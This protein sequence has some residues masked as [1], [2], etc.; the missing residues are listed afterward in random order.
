MSLVGVASTGRKL[1]RV[2]PVLAGLV[3]GAALGPV[4]RR[5][6]HRAVVPTATTR[7]RT[8]RGISRNGSVEFQK[9]RHYEA[10]REG[11]RHV[12]TCTTCHG[13]V[14]ASLLSPKG[15]ESQCSRCHGPGKAR[16]NSD[17]PPEGRILLSSVREVRQ[18]LDRARDLLGR[19]KDKPRRAELEAAYTQAEVPLI[20]AVNAGHAFVFT[21]LR[22]R[23]ETAR[24]RSEVL[25]ED[26]ANPPPP[27]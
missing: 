20:E 25:L 7:T 4:L 17:Y 8:P 1:G 21:A 22:E 2:G 26:L 14:A 11:D 3:L 15:L 16:P 13:E 24:R 9:S 12:P 23:L 27:R 10:L 19:V 18:S 5:P 6:R